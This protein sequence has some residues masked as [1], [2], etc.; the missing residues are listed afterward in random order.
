MQLKGVLTLN[1]IFVPCVCESSDQ[2]AHASLL[3]GS[4]PD[5]VDSEDF[6]IPLPAAIQ[7]WL[8]NL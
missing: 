8:I 4:P 1:K 5:N 3:D 6:N 7:A 2:I